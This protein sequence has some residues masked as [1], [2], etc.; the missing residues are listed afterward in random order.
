MQRTPAAYYTGDAADATS[1]TTTGNDTSGERIVQLA[2]TFPHKGGIK[3]ASGH[4]V[5]I[6]GHSRQSMRALTA[7]R[8]DQGK[9]NKDLPM[10][11]HARDVNKENRC[12]AC[13][14][15][16]PYAPGAVAQ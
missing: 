16:L 1:G 13:W 10:R 2:C 8:R 9:P 3:Q 7:A 12:S 4:F 6:S 11:M 5:R 15:D 14:R